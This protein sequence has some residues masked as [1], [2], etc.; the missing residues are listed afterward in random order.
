MYIVNSHIVL[1]MFP[2]LAKLPNYAELNPSLKTEL[3]LFSNPH[4]RKAIEGAKFARA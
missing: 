3:V 2:K 4:M 1:S